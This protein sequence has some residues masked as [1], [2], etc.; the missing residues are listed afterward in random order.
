MEK[1]EILNRAGSGNFSDVYKAKDTLTGEIVAI[2]EMK[3]CEDIEELALRQLKIL[4]TLNHPNIVQLKEVIMNQ[5]DI[6]VV[7]EYV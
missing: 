5:G 7:F 3:Q 2:K 1:Y 4:S 6:K